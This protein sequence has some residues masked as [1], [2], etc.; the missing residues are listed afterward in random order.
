MNKKTHS[1]SHSHWQGRCC[2]SAQ[3]PRWYQ[4]FIWFC[5]FMREIYMANINS[6]DL[7]CNCSCCCRR[8]QNVFAQDSRFHILWIF[9]LINIRVLLTRSSRKTRKPEKTATTA[10]ATTA[11][12][13]AMCIVHV[14]DAHSDIRIEMRTWNVLRTLNAKQFPK[15]IKCWNH[16]IQCLFDANG[17][18]T[19]RN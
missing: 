6:Y 5:K 11:C 8:W 12:I 17:M 2:F 15:T 18:W 9:C 16:T 19:K 13:L 10:T 7:H 14:Y 4:H 1:H 3:L